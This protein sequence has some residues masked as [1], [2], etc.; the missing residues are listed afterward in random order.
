MTEKA[1]SIDYEA[2]RPSLDIRI[3]TLHSGSDN[4]PITCSLHRAARGACK[5]KALSYE[6]REESDND[7]NI[8]IEN[9]S[10]R[11]R[12]NLSHALRNIRLPSEDVDLWVDAI[13]I[14]QADVAE[15]SNQV[16]MMEETFSNATS[17]I[18]W[19]GTAHSDSDIAMDWLSD[20]STIQDR[21][22]S[23]I[24]DSLEFQALVSF[25]NRPYWLRIWIIQELFL[26]RSYIVYCGSKSIPDEIFDKSFLLLAATNSQ[27]INLSAADYHISTRRMNKDVPSVNRMRRWIALCSKLGFQC[28]REHDRIYGLLGI[29]HDYKFVEQNIDVDYSKS[30]RELFIEVIQKRFLS[31][32]G[33]KRICERLAITMNVELDDELRSLITS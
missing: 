18:V 10:V 15:K 1:L 16:A 26:S 5:Y 11:V 21:V 28:S 17:V 6:W 30:P 27:G 29:S 7:P 4:D 22:S 12:Q 9:Q 23:H 3:L 8:V 31:W 2:I 24:R 20:P 13:C 32:Y 14:N 25:C 19:L 33:D